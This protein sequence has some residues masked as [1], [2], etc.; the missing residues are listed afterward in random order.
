M[1]AFRPS[2][3]RRQHAVCEPSASTRLPDATCGRQD[4]AARRTWVIPGLRLAPAPGRRVRVR[5][6]GRTFPPARPVSP[7]RS[8]QVDL[9]EGLG[10]VPV[11]SGVVWAARVVARCVGITHGMAMAHQERLVK[12]QR[13][14]LETC[15]GAGVSVPGVYV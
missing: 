3:D 6:D 5:C 4:S 12:I 15:A 10:G 14:C 11:A 7:G 13:D 2:V 9:R 8:G 1:P